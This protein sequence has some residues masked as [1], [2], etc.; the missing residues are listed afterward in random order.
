MSTRKWDGLGSKKG[1]ENKTNKRGITVSAW[2]ADADDHWRE[3]IDISHGIEDGSEGDST[4]SELPLR[5]LFPHH[6][7]TQILG[8]YM[9]MFVCVH[10][11]CDNEGGLLCCYLHGYAYSHTCM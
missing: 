7:N 2:G 8:R 11:T 5:L 4:R 1:T 6:Y 9:L 10:F 3:L